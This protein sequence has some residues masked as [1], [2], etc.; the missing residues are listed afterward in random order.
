MQFS[1]ILKISITLLTARFRQSIVA[2]VGVAFG[3][4]MFIILMGFMTGLNKLLDGLI[5]NRTP[6]I[7]IYNEIKASDVQPV[8][9]SPTFKGS[10]HFI[11]SIKPRSERQ[12]LNNSLAII[13]TLSNDSRV[14]G[15][16]PR[17]ATQVFYTAGMTN[18]NGVIFGI[19]VIEENRLFQFKDYVV[20]GNSNDLKVV[21]NSIILGIGIADKLLAEPGDNIQI[22]S[23]TGERFML[24]V[25][26]IFQSG[27]AEL[28]NVQSYASLQTTQKVMGKQSGF[29]T[30]IHVKL[31]DINLAPE[32]AVR[33][34]EL[35]NVDAI[36]IQKANAQFETG[37]NIRNII[38]YAVSITL[39][40]V[41]GFGIY[42]ILNMMIYEKMDSIAIMKATGFSGNDV[43]N[44]FLTISLIIGISGGVAGLSLGLLGSIGIDQIPFVTESL[45]T[46]KTY[47]INYNPA[48]Y[49]IGIFFSIATTYIAGLF[50]ALKA[51]KIDPVE[52][53]RG[54]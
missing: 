7:R 15:I 13:Q 37:S 17:V 42:N 26:G 25:V 16:A 44:I 5:L 6:H 19:D 41:A 53:I 50:P 54:K 52:I 35:F 22:I 48:Y 18:I 46:I 39:L 1:L 36:D 24:K 33:Y 14:N 8:Q 40:V 49:A 4:M 20:L 45:P 12:E 27:I 28:D 30:D 32:M 38:T 43:K 23:A 10:V 51:S 29:I 21:G 31:H 3:I 34:N 47:P 11:H 9:L 2:A